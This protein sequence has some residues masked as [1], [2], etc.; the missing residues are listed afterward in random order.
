MV[1]FIAGAV[2]KH[3]DLLWI[4]AV[5]EYV[6]NAEK[7]IRE[8]GIRIIDFRKYEKYELT[9]KKTAAA[10]AVETAG[11][12]DRSRP[13]RLCRIGSRSRQNDHGVRHRKNFHLAVHRRETRA[14]EKRRHFV[15]RPVHRAGRAG[16]AGMAA[17]HRAPARLHGDL[18]GQRR[19]GRNRGE[20]ISHTELSC[21]VTTKP[22]EIAEQLKKS[23]GNGARVVF[24]TYQS[25]NKLRDA[26]HKH[27]APDFDL[28]LVD[29][30]HRT[31]G[32]LEGNRAG[33]FQLIHKPKEIRAKK[34][35]YMTATPRVY[36]I[37]EKNRAENEARI[38]DMNDYETYG[39]EFYRLSFRKAV[40]KDMLCDY[41]VIALGISE[42]AMT[43]DLSRRLLELNVE[44]AGRAADEQAI[45]AL[46]AI[47]L[48]VNGAVRGENSPGVLA[49]TIAYASN[50][51]RS[52][53]L[54]RALDADE[55]KSWIGSAALPITA[56]HLDGTSSALKRGK[57]L[58]ALN[59]AKESAPRLISNAQLFTEGV[60]VPALNAVAFLDPRQSKVDTIQAVGRVMRRA[61]KKKFGYIV[62]PVILPPN[63]DLLQVLEED[64]AR[65]KTLGNVLSALQSHDESLYTELTERLTFANINRDYEHDSDRPP[66]TDLQ[67]QKS[68]L[69]EDAQAG[70]FR[71]DCEKHRHRQ[72]RQDHRRRDHFRY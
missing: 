37:K 27:G 26:Q 41:K 6:S 43:G 48:A 31:T 17:A 10:K 28:A 11:S 9:S 63:A 20:D 18:L 54:A 34:R 72:P 1:D 50:I 14:E 5:N 69:D 58:R 12:G 49:R 21:R 64:Q 56:E 53:W 7:L 15:H 8:H 57:E 3:F 29:E 62:V 39:R 70:N 68:L 40:G 46:G 24:C 55:V 19:A 42:A 47:A 36:D 25:L 30:A 45:L 51:R 33:L 60:D 52:K 22:A 66:Q 67:V 32:Y 61:E 44:G 65:F 4:V 71:A 38:V 13:A 23:A 59:A 16:A 35:L 2:K